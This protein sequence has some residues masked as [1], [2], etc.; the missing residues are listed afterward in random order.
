MLTKRLDHHTMKCVGIEPV[1]STARIIA[2]RWYDNDV[3]YD[4]M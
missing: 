3:R 2:K 4:S 1:A